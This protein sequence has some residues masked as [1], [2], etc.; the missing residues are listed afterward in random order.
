MNH[1]KNQYNNSQSRISQSINKSINIENDGI[2]Y[3]KAEDFIM[4]PN[5]IR[6][7]ILKIFNRTE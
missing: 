7:E 5:Y 6:E 4:P 2:L 1:I 3:S